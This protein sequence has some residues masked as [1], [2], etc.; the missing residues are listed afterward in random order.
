MVK[1]VAS[2]DKDRILLSTYHAFVF[3]FIHKQIDDLDNGIFFSRSVVNRKDIARHTE[4]KPIPNSIMSLLI[5]P[6]EFSFVY[7]V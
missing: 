1:K 6:I 5:K 4:D 2:R 3:F 7:M